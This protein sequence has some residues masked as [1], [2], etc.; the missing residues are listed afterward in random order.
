MARRADGRPGATIQSFIDR[1]I[2]R[3]M[4]LSMVTLRR[5]PPEAA[6][7]RGPSLV[8]VAV[9]FV[10]LFVASLVI[11]TAMAGG[12]HFPS[13]FDPAERS[14]RYFDQHAGAVQLAAFLQFGSAIPLGIFAA[15]ATSRVQF[16]GMKVAG[17]NIALFGGIAASMSLAWCASIEW[18]LSQAR[19]VEA[20]GVTRALH[21]LSF[22]TGGPGQIAPFGLLVAGVSLVAGLQGLAPRWLMIFGLG[23]AAFAELSTLVFVLPAAAILLPV[24]RFSGFVW[25]ICMGASLPRARVAAR[26]GG[27]A[28]AL[29]QDAPQA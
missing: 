26:R 5:N 6:S 14:A 8:M 15:T 20:S 29:L 10:L 4:Y 2:L 17:I 16:L 7:H 13:P 27:P 25:M 3:P 9:V 11:P 24:A 1:T 12:Q 19:L 22:A 21:L 23:I 18:V 28:P